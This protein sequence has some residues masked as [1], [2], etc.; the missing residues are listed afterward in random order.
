MA[1]YRQRDKEIEEY[2]DLEPVLEGLYM[3][4]EAF[5]RPIKNVRI[6]YVWK[7]VDIIAENAKFVVSGYAFSG[8]EDG[9]IS[10]LN[11]NHLDCAMVVNR[12]AEII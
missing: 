5:L 4:K 10:I 2:I 3:D 7:E 11:L 6:E 9:L 12:K 1:K 8:Q